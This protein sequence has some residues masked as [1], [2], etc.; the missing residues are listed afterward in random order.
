VQEEAGC[1]EGQVH[2]DP[3]GHSAPER[4]KDEKD[5]EVTEDRVPETPELA[6]G[7]G[8]EGHEEE[9]SQETNGMSRVSEPMGDEPMETRR[10]PSG[11]P[12]L[13]G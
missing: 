10:L 8:A 4:P 3:S 6:E 13:A 11:A 9:V 5:Q 7:P 12:R 1:Q 2:R